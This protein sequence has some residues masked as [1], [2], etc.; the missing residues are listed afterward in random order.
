MKNISYLIL[1]LFWGSLVSA[2]GVFSNQTNAVLEKVIQD[3][4]NHFKNLRGELLASGHQLSEYKSTLGMPGAVSCTIRTWNP[5]ASRQ[6]V[7][8]E[9]TISAGQDFAAASKKYQEFYGQIKN[10][11]IR[12]QGER[13]VILNGHYEA[14]EADRKSN[15][16][17]FELLPYN[18]ATQR[19][20]VELILQEGAGGEWKITLSVF[21]KD[22]KEEEAL[23]SGGN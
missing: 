1:A 5:E 11:I 4:P 7:S 20:R 19:L 9:A 22:R 23:V 12:L 14:P 6:V 18:P 8:W 13:P 3:F 21:D 2:Q 10:T 15:S 17:L 16:I